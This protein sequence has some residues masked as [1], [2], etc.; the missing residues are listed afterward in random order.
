MEKKFNIVYKNIKNINIRIRSSSEIY[1][2]APFGTP[3]SYL[4]KVLAK[5]ALWIDEKLKLYEEC[6]I[7][8]KLEYKSGEKILYLGEY[9]RLEVVES[10]RNCLFI[11]DKKVE[12]FVNNKDDFE[13]KEKIVQKWYMSQ[14]RK[15]FNELIEKYSVIV[16]KDIYRVSIKKMRTRWGSCNHTKGYINLNLHLIKT[17][18]ECIE[19][20]VFH[21]LAHLVYPNHSKKFY[22]FVARYMS[23]FKSKEEKLKHFRLSYM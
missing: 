17:P 18:K 22:A 12:L 3:N 5:R 10:G 7:P 4:Q 23:D 8:K 21:E 2:S 16:Q 14:A 13:Q 15:L 20:V 19:Y 6:K 1:V 9:Y 11:N